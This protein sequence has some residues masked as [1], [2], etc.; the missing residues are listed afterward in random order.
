M[1]VG[2]VPS[3]RHSI[4]RFAKFAETEIAF[5]AVVDAVGPLSSCRFGFLL[6]RTSLAVSSPSNK[7]EVP[8]RAR[9][10]PA[11][12]PRALPREF[13]G[14]KKRHLPTDGRRWKPTTV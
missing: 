11:L 5:W 6:Q 3:I 4:A 8:L 9:V 7:L 12:I 10:R 14:R 2:E 1:D 13:G